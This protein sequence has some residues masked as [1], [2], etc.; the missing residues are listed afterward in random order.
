MKKELLPSNKR[1]FDVLYEQAQ[2]K[3]QKGS[4]F[5]LN[6]SMETISFENHL[7][8]EELKKMVGFTSSEVNLFLFRIT[9]QNETVMFARRSFWKVPGTLNKVKSETLTKK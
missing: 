2:T 6:A 1:K 5:I 3:T 9:E 7:I 8:L 4:E